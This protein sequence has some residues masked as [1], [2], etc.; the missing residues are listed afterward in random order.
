MD[1]RSIY[2]YRNLLHWFYVNFFFH[3]EQCF[4]GPSMLQDLLVLHCFLLL[5]IILLYEYTTFYLFI[6][7]LM[8]NW[9]VFTY[10]LSWIILL[11]KCAYHILYRHM[12]SFLLAICLGVELLG[13]M[14]TF[15]RTARLF[16]KRW[17]H[18]IFLSAVYKDCNISIYLPIH[19]IICLL[20]FS[21]A[22]GCE[23]V[24]NCG[25]ELHF[26]AS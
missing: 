9:I 26:L 4:Q 24:F 8:D 17:H 18:F 5:K 10:C 2:I 14:V 6:Y 7:Q 3:L 21:H 25:F 12:F 20:C 19:F 23:E 15:L 11:W 13:H 1:A 22:S 16:A